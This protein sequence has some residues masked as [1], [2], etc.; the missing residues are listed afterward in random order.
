MTSHFTPERLLADAKKLRLTPSEKAEGRS[1]L[2]AR[3]ALHAA[4]AIRLSADEKAMGRDALMATMRLQ[5]E[6]NEDRA[7]WWNTFVVFPL[8]RMPALALSALIVLLGSGAIAYAAES[9]IPGDPLYVLKVDVLEPLRERVIRTPEKRAAWQIKKIERRLGEARKLAA[10]GRLTQEHR[11]QIEHQISEQ[12]VTLKDTPSSSLETHV[13]AQEVLAVAFE[14]YE[15]SVASDIVPMALRVYEDVPSSAPEGAMG[16]MPKNT[17]EADHLL[18][19]VKERTAAARGEITYA[20]TQATG[21]TDSPSQSI[22][23]AAKRVLNVTGT[24]S[25]KKTHSK[26]SAQSSPSD[27]REREDDI[28]DRIHSQIPMLKPRDQRS[29]V[30]LQRSSSEAQSSSAVASQEISTGVNAESESDVYEDSSVEKEDDTASEHERKL[31]KRV[32]EK[33]ELIEEQLQGF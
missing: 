26:D 19:F 12:V 5:S 29:S 24:G 22:E 17:I 14:Q 23:A 4:A 30:S 8:L 11:Q 15:E 32:Q 31:L 20:L 1:L 33:K 28:E 3:I 25:A 6:K 10:A 2:L 18:K 9:A 27:D 7:P 16:G 21:G 13:A